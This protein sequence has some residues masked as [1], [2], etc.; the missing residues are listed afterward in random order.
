MGRQPNGSLWFNGSIDL[1]GVYNRA[2]SP[3]EVKSLSADPYSPV[4]TILPGANRRSI[5]FSPGWSPP[6]DPTSDYTLVQTVGPTL[7]TGTPPTVPF[8]ISPTAGNALVVMIAQ[9]TA[10][11]RTYSVIDSDDTDGSE[12]TKAVGGSDGS[13]Y[14]E[15]WYRANIP[16]GITSVTV[17][18]NQSSTTF[19]AEVQ[20]WNGFGSAITVEDS[21]TALEGGSS[22]NHY[23]SVTGV[24]TTEDVVAFA[25]GLL[26]SAATECYA[27]NRFTEIAFTNG[28]YLFQYRKMPAGGWTIGDWWSSGTDRTGQ[29]AIALLKGAG[30]A[31][32]ET[33]TMDK[34]FVHPQMPVY[35]GFE[36][37]SY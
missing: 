21:D 36:V 30:G 23:C 35:P 14:T 19:Y 16:A 7:A 33:I 18:H 27:G 1:I 13:R 28:T 8:T 5:P 22:D 26:S 2:L 37:V 15:I 4:A 6:A 9:S 20:E 11:A 32:P 34:W 25:V 17:K 12:W 29:G 24:T 31:A 3:A 10:S